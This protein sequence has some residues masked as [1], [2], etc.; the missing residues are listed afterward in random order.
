VSPALLAIN[1]AAIAAALAAGMLA[2]RLWRRTREIHP[3]VYNQLL[4][5]AAGRIR[6]L[7]ICGVL[8]GFGALAAIIFDLIALL[9][10]PPCAG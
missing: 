8:T 1:L 5:A 10:V 2:L 4:P 6:F 7:A 9:A 3:P